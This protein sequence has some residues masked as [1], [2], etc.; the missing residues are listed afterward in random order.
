MRFMSVIMM[1]R[2]RLGRRHTM[3]RNLNFIIALLGF[4]LDI[5]YLLVLVLM[6]NFLFCEGFFS[7]FW[8]F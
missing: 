2:V 5:L 8:Y 6:F 4:T 3:R 1:I 7:G